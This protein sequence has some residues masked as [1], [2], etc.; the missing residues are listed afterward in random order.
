MTATA[1]SP[2][3]LV[4]FGAGA[5]Y[6]SSPTLR[7]TTPKHDDR[8]PLADELFEERP[9][10]S[11]N[12]RRFPRCLGLIANLRHRYPTTLTVEQELDR[13]LQEA[14]YYAERHAQLM[15]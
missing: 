12:L 14:D 13:F 6:D 8:P 9:M 7:P 3:L 15:A 1:A 5:S 10:F 2:V 11:Q 4:I